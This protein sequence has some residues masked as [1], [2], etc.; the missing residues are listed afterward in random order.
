MNKLVLVYILSSVTLRTTVQIC[1]VT[2]FFI[3]KFALFFKVYK[4]ICL[5]D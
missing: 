1:W 4:N 3:E 2:I 5:A